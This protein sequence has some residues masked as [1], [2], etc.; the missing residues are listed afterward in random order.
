MNSRRTHLYDLA[1]AFQR[2]APWQW[3]SETQLI[4]LRHPETGEL[5]W[6][7]LMGASGHHTSLALYL[8]ES[9]LERFHLIQQSASP[10]VELSQ[11]DTIRLIFESRQLQVNLA[12]RDELFR[13]ELAEIKALG[14]KYR[15]ENWP[16]FRSFRPGWAPVP[17]AG[18]EE[19]WLE[20]AL[21][22]L[23]AVTPD[24]E[25]SPMGHLRVQNGRTHGLTRASV[26]GVWQT[27]WTPE[28]TRVY[29]FPELPTDETLVAEVAGNPR[30]VAVECE[31]RVLPVPVGK[32]GVS[33]VFPYV[34]VCVDSQSGMVLGLDTLAVESMD[35]ATMMA[36]VPT[37]FMEIWNRA[38]IRP[39]SIGVS[40]ESARAALA[41]TARALG[42]PLVKEPFFPALDE[43]LDSLM[44]FLAR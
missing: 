23:L 15:G 25:S 20:C 11:F 16:C 28:D 35:F 8:G 9:P 26:D 17:V 7:S 27:T 33:A 41:S 19:R 43:A 3:M 32:E 34:V 14:R 1:D 31:F 10:D 29:Q 5:G 40:S 39:S 42:V 4:G 38:G 36:V 44:Q 18:D 24:L 21:E 37:R 22:Q 2:L 30:K 13:S 6:M 12:R